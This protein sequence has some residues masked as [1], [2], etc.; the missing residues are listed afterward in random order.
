LTVIVENSDGATPNVNDA[1]AW[2]TDHDLQGE[3]LYD[4]DRTWLQEM[5]TDDWQYEPGTRE[6]PLV[7]MVHTSNLLIWDVFIDW[8]DPLSGTMWNTHLILV[9]EIIDDFKDEDGAIGDD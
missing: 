1:L 7:F 6:W 2:K 4:A 9:R 8:P 3:V 5:R